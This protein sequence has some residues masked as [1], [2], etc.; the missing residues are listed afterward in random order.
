MSTGLL[1]KKIR[2][3]FFPPVNKSWMGGVNYYRNLFYALKEYKDCNLEI[4]LF[5]PPNFD[6]DVVKLYFPFVDEHHVI[7]LLDK[8]RLGGF[9]SKVEYRLFGKHNLLERTLNHYRI[10]VISHVTDVNFGGL[11]R[12]KSI[13]WIP[14]FQH[15][16]LPETFSKQEIRMRDRGFMKLIQNTDAIFLS[17]NDALSDFKSF[18]P[19]YVDRVRVLQF[20]SQPEESY[21][22][23]DKGDHQALLLKY[24]IPNNY[25]Y[26]PNQF[27]KHKNH[28]IAFNAVKIL[29]DSGIDIC[30]VCTGSLQDYRS[31]AYIK[32]LQD[33]VSSNYLE[34][35]IRL[36]GLVPYKDVFALIN[37]SQAV[38][39]PSLFEGWS[40]TVEECKSVG[41]PMILSDI[42]VHKEQLPDAV[43]FD[44]FDAAS[45]AN[46]LR[47]YNST[48]ESQSDNKLQERTENY[49]HNFIRAINFIL[50]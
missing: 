29:R 11:K 14:D 25:F 28:L 38:I 45:L 4:V 30:L 42:N 5:L 47:G 2:V 31:P 10:D 13:G 44:R 19:S 7:G 20:V 34:N 12:I 23:I 41:K 43:F 46:I 35:N 50:G 15:L 37:F 17:S 3:G 18:A 39:N 22:K 6:D 16:H 24:Q 1:S 21:L 33:Y 40:S 9:L 32:L 49:G 27:W 26:L 8:K 36:L 48:N